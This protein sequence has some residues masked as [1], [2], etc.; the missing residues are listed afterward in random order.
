VH[1]INGHKEAAY[2]PIGGFDAKF[3][4]VR[5][6]TIFTPSESGSHY[7]GCSGIGPTKVTINDRVVYDQKGDCEDAMAFLLG[8]IPEEEF[9]YSFTKGV[10]YQIHIQ[11]TVERHTVVFSRAYPASVLDL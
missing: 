10:S 7:L 11:T 6:S 5:L 2:S 9:N 4:D 3:K 8:G 1:T